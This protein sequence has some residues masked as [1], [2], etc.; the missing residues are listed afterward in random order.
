M[1]LPNKKYQIIYCDPAWQYDDKALAGNRGAECKY[2]VME[3]SALKLIP[4]QK[5]ADE[6]CVLFMWCTFPML[7]SG[8]ELI[9][10]WGF[11]YKTVAFTWLKR[12]K[13]SSNFFMGMGTWTR[14]NQE[15]V[16]L[17]VKGKPKRVSAGVRQIIDS[18][19]REHSKKPAVVRQ[20]IIQL[21]G[22]LPRIELF[23]RT[24]VH[25]WDVVGNDPK[26]DNKPLEVFT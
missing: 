13:N 10:A 26:L 9:N 18:P 4:I 20:R 6:N 15:I 16:L 17:A 3:L 22:D 2:D 19:I 23:A 14:S 12:N 1:N 11:Q 21:C 8:L 5:I 7:D 25:G 24:K